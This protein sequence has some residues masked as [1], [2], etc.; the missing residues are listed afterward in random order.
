MLDNMMIELDIKSVGFI[1]F[2]ILLWSLAFQNLI[3]VFKRELYSTNSPKKEG[4]KA[5][6]WGLGYF[7][8]CRGDLFKA[9]RTNF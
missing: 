9:K 7:F 5:I 2:S 3:G 1:F 8:L 4:I 6:I